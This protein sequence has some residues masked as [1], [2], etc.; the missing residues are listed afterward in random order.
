MAQKSVR[1]IRCALTD[2]EYHA[3]YNQI[4]EATAIA[5]MLRKHMGDGADEEETVGVRLIRERLEAVK[6]LLEQHWLDT[7]NPEA[8]FR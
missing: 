6:G 8:R 7:N 1:E 2:G 3:L 5:S 4:A